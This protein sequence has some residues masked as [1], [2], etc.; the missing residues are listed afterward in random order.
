[1]IDPLNHHNLQVVPG[2][3][4]SK[5]V[6]PHTGKQRNPGRDVIRVASEVGSF[7]LSRTGRNI[8]DNNL[9][10]HHLMPDGIDLP[11]ESP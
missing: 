11:F 6:F 1:M 5:I 8:F 2:N 10:N 7:V 9:F 3:R 4:K